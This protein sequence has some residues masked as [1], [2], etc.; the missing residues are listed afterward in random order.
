[1]RIARRSAVKLV[2]APALLVGIAALS[3]GAVLAGVPARAQDSTSRP[4]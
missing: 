2:A 3:F 1:M 4:G